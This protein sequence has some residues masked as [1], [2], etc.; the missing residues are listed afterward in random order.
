MTISYSDT[1]VKLLLR[2]KGSLWK[3]IWKHLL[4][5]LLCYYAINMVY[6]LVALLRLKEI[7]AQVLHDGR[8]AG[9]LP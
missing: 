7:I 5:F 1:F 9:H 6:R 4:V 3:A 2:W 8:A